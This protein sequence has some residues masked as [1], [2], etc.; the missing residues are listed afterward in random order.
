MEEQTNNNNTQQEQT[1]WLETPEGQEALRERITP[2]ALKRDE[3]LQ[4]TKKERNAR[5][6]LEEKNAKLQQQLEEYRI[7]ENMGA[8]NKHNTD[9]EFEAKVKARL[10]LVEDS[11]QGKLSEAEKQQKTLLDELNKAKKEKE[12]LVLRTTL[13]QAAQAAGV[14]P[15]AVDDLLAR[16]ER[17]LY[18]KE[19]KVLVR[20][21]DGEDYPAYGPNGHEPMSPVEWANALKERAPHLFQGSAGVGA[22]GS[23]GGDKNPI[24]VTRLEM[25][26][27]KRYNEVTALH[28][29]TGR[30]V[31][32]MD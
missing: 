2:L 14:L 29:Q 25:Q 3:L 19:N 6:E 4:E 21:P 32:V 11:F 23:Q 7:R 17:E 16:G 8:G 13:Q 9:E 22:R 26:N 24:R 12:T 18:V 20:G 30:P 10:R 31:E 15:T 1:S 28:E 27:L 5:R